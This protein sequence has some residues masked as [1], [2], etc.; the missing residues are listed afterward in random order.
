MNVLREDPRST[1]LRQRWGNH[2]YVFRI[3]ELYVSCQFNDSTKTVT[4]YRIFQ[5]EGMGEADD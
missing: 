2:C 5:N 4:V 1:Y 3:A